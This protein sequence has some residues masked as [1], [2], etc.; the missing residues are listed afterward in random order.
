[1]IEELL[2]TCKKNPKLDPKA[3]YIDLIEHLKFIVQKDA[4]INVQAAA[5]KLVNALAYGLRSKFAHHAPQFF[6]LMFERFKEKKALL[7]DPLAECCDYLAEMINLENILDDITAAMGKPNPN[8]KQQVDQ[9]LFRQ[10]V[11]FS[12]AEQPKKL[13]K[14]I[15]PVLLK[16]AEDS[17]K[18]VRDC[19]CLT[20]GGVL[21]L[22]S[23]AIFQQ[24]AG[25]LANDANKMAKVKEGKENAEKE[26]AGNQA[27][28]QEAA[29]VSA[30]PVQSAPAA[31]SG[32]TTV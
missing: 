6:P 3:D 28:K 27:A 5:V 11:R 20:L 22:T 9:F 18:D 17:D 16:H 14:A 21:R 1:V 32:S 13:I 7:R 29:G 25:D 19:S 26:Y 2:N 15:V 8:I 31:A 4:N 10:L 12:P 23:D 30:P 24:L